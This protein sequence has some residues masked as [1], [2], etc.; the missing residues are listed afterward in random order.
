MELRGKNLVFL[1][2]SITEGTGVAL[3]ENIYLN[4]LRQM[5]GAASALN[6]GI[7]GTSIARNKDE[8]WRTGSFVVRAQTFPEAVWHADVT[9]IF[10]GT[11]DYGIGDAQF[12]DEESCSPFE[13]NGAVN[14]LVCTLRAMKADMEIVLLSPLRRMNEVTTNVATNQPLNAYVELLRKAADRNHVHFCDLYHANLFDPECSVQ[15]QRYIPDGLHP[16]D[17]GHRLIAEKVA[18]LVSQLPDAV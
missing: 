12:G 5:T 18:Q 15:R 8:N 9:F 13:I 4:R 2:D 10:G 11:N 16:N 17:E 6:L 7:G 1:G 3:D 14:I